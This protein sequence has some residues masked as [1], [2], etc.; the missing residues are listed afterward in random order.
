VVG[1]GVAGVVAMEHARARGESAL[2]VGRDTAPGGN[3]LRVVPGV[4]LTSH[5]RYLGLPGA[6]EIVTAADMLAYVTERCRRLE[7]RLGDG[8]ARVD[9]APGGFRIETESGTTLAARRVVV[10][11]GHGPPRGVPPHHH[12]DATR[13][14]PLGMPPPAAPSR[15]LVLGGGNTAVDTALALVGAG[16][17]VR[18]SVRSCPVV[19][20][21][22]GI[23]QMWD[24]EQFM[25]LHR[26]FPWVI[27]LLP[28]VAWLHGTSIRG[29]VPMQSPTKPSRLV[30]DRGGF[31]RMVRAS[32]PSCLPAS[33]PVSHRV[34]RVQSA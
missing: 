17:E 4:A 19:A 18:M 14:D 28:A 30:V 6:P 10:A 12:I 13:V 7:V 20:P 15:I 33:Q 22:H 3:W 31:S 9:K 1:S 5:S 24:I 27:R 29:A 16:H 2:M 21:H 23:L 25:C 8:V 26:R 34:Q 32:L 11:T